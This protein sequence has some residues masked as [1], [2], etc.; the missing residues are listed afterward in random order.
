MKF[1]AGYKDL[2]EMACYQLKQ[3]YV[4]IGVSVKWLPLMFSDCN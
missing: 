2:K 3:S 1:L 4:K